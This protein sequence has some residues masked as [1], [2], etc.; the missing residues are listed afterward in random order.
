MK[1][2]TTKAFEFQAGD[3]RVQT[4]R[5]AFMEAP[6]QIKED[7]Y[8]KKACEDGDVEIIT[9]AKQQKKLENEPKAAKDRTKSGGQ[10]TEQG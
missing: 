7:L 4:K 3:Q 5:L 9:T 1:I 2:F 6:D 10:Q 8:F